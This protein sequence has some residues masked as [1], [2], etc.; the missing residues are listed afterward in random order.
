MEILRGYDEWKTTPPDDPDYEDGGY[1]CAECGASDHPTS[2]CPN[3]I[4][5]ES[6]E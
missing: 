5:E 2:E 3:C 6:D 1:E 4:K